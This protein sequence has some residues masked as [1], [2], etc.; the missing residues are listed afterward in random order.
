MK[1]RPKPRKY[2]HDELEESYFAV[3][4]NEGKQNLSRDDSGNET[5]DKSDFYDSHKREFKIFDKNIDE[6]GYS[7]NEIKTTKYNF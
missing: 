1:I 2:G 4:S 7:S 3:N 6:K 5:T